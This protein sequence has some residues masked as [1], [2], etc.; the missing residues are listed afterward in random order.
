MYENEVNSLKAKLSISLQNSP[1]ERQAQLIANSIVAAKRKAN[2]DISK[3]KDKEKKVRANAL[4]DARELTNA[5]RHYITITDKEWKAIQSGAVSDSM[6]SS[7]IRFTKP[8]DITKRVAPKRTYSNMSSA[9]LSRARS[10]LNSGYTMAEV[11][12]N[13]GVSTTTLSK[14]LKGE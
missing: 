12:D 8:E 7:I 9:T 2:P 6:L 13:L 14:A 1:R 5:K 11:A 3:D 4:R 10:W